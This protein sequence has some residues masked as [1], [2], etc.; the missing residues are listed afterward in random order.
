MAD[1]DKRRAADNLLSLV[2]QATDLASLS[3]DAKEA[4]YLHICESC[5][6]DPYTR[7]FEYIN[8]S[9]KTVLY[10]KKEATDKL[11]ALHH[12]SIT[13]L[14]REIQDGIYVVV[15]QAKLP[16]GRIDES[17]GAV[18]LVHPDWT[19]DW[20]QEGNKRVKK[21]VKN[22]LAGQPLKA[23]DRANA[24]MKAETKAKRRVTLSIIGLGMLDE[25]EIEGIPDLGAPPTADTSVPGLTPKKP[26]TPPAQTNPP[27]ADASPPAGAANDAPP[28][29]QSQT[30][31]EAA[32]TPAQP[33]EQ[34]AT[35]QGATTETG[36]LMP[37]MR[38]KTFEAKLKSANITE[39][40][41]VK[42]FGKPLRGADGKPQLLKSQSAE[43][44]AFILNPQ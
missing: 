16:T 20:V 36:E 40:Q 4:Y 15:A 11:R 8:L 5:G 43:I 33:T 25:S 24:C 18:A 41:F 42:R 7:P 3:P 26:D 44:D 17:I 19:E 9:G 10:A 1:E 31:S 6:L 39:E 14:S 37:D 34:P 2:L 32:A 21:K 30:P 12:V 27:P 38:C 22:T 23:L 28:A 29:Q 13:I 35:T